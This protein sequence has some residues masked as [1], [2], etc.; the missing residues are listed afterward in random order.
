MPHPRD[1]CFECPRCFACPREEIDR[2]L[3]Y[4]LHRFWHAILALLFTLTLLCGCRTTTQH[5]F[6]PL[7]VTA[8]V[9]VER[10]K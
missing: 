4:R 8:V 3:P 6:G 7:T 9:D 1:F 5:T 10:T 2:C